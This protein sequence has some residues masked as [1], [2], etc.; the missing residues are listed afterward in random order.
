MFGKDHKH[1]GSKLRYIPRFEVR[2]LSDNYI[3]HTVWDHSLI[4]E[5]STLDQ[6]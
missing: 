4:S 6:G 5:Q 3:I 2:F 1:N